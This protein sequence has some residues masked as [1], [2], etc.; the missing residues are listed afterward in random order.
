MLAILIQG[1]TGWHPVVCAW[2]CGKE[3]SG[4]EEAVEFLEQLSECQPS[5]MTDVFAWSLFFDTE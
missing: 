5:K 2:E 3:P 1:I 4:F